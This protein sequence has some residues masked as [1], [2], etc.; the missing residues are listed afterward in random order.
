MNWSTNPVPLCSDAYSSWNNDNSEIVRKQHNQEVTDATNRLYNQVIPELANFL[1][2]TCIRFPWNKLDSSQSKGEIKHLMNWL[3]GKHQ[4]HNR[5]VN[6]RQ[7]GFLRT[8]VKSE[9]V[10]EL[11]LIIC[12][13]RLVKD[14]LKDD[15]RSTM[16][17]SR[18]PSDNPFKTEI[19]I[20]LN[21]ILGHEQN[22]HDWWH[23]TLKEGLKEKYIQC[24]SEEEQH[25]SLNL[26]DKVNL[27][28][29]FAYL[30]N[31]MGI[32]LRSKALHH[33]ITKISDYRFVVSDIKSLDAKIAT[34]Y[35]GPFSDAMKLYSEASP[36]EN[37]VAN[38]ETVRL[39]EA[40]ISKFRNAHEDSSTCPII[41]HRWANAHFA[42]GSILVNEKEK[43]WTRCMLLFEKSL[44]LW[45]GYIGALTDYSKFLKEYCK[46]LV[47]TS[48]IRELEE[49][50][51]YMLQRVSTLKENI[52]GCYS[53]E[54]QL[55]NHNT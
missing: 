36:S 9:R 14:R 54:S 49:K 20:W 33:L 3:V 4:L 28:F 35:I 23:I 52:L 43:H 2:E 24:L 45:P 25:P 34:G 51:S 26:K 46:T 40:C 11:L 38:D 19:M 18:V 13:S 27:R 50:A 1:D 30:L 32:K 22:S 7:M 16:M 47:E 29:L 42:L 48:K 15:M 44:L 53:R 12:I 17:R 55:E 37:P 21:R 10:K 5:G 41:L 8:H 39:L 31:L 6:M